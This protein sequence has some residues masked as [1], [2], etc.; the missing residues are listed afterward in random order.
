MKMSR[1]AIG[2]TEQTPLIND[3]HD[4]EEEE[5]KPLPW[6]PIIVLLLLTAAQ[7]LA[8]EI[9]FPFISTKGALP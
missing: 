9:I 8:Y 3:L 7:P 1:S 6:R 4:S 2:D 5:P